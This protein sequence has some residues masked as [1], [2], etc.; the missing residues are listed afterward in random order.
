MV[1]RMRGFEYLEV[2]DFIA[3]EDGSFSW[4]SD[5]IDNQCRYMQGLSMLKPEQALQ[6]ALMSWLEIRLPEVR[7][8]VIASAGGL[9]TAKRQ[10]SRMK[11]MGYLRGTPDLFFPFPRKDFHGL[12]I[13]LKEKA[14]VSKEQ[15]NVLIKLGKQG[16]KA[17]VCRGWDES[18]KAIKGYFDLE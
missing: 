14:S 5:N 4:L 3:Q 16:Y 17:V 8:L 11:R 9:W 7:K 6:I 15:R 10:G 12:F 1:E 2:K 18:I 13:E